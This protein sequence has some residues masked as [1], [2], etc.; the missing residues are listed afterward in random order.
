MQV[1]HAS[2]AQACMHGKRPNRPCK[3]GVRR[4]DVG[5]IGLAV[6]IFGFF[7]WALFDDFL[8]SLDNWALD[9]KWTHDD[10]NK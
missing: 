7:K 4:R 2:G 10:N 1:V 9:I 8:I 6:W 5:V 3:W